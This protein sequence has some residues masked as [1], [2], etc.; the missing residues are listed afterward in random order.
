MRANAGE[1][2]LRDTVVSETAPS[3]RVE[4][5][6]DRHSLDWYDQSHEP[7]ALKPGD[8]LFIACR[9]G[10]C[11]SRLEWFTPRLEI[12]ER[13]GI[14]VLDDGRRDSWID[15][16]GSHRGELDQVSAGVV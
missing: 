6:A 9:G 2:V 1:A 5:S 15:L 8:R 12:A 3:R 11:T 7:V 10:S 16:L 13:D 4:E 14:Y